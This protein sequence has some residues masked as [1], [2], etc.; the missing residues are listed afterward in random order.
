MQTNVA[1]MLTVMAGSLLCGSADAAGND[2]FGLADELGSV[3]AAALPYEGR[4]S[5]RQVGEPAHDSD[6]STGSLTTNL[7]RF[8]VAA[9]TRYWIRSA[10][11]QSGYFGKLTF[12]IRPLTQPANDRF[13]DALPLA[14][15]RIVINTINFGASTE[16]GEPPPQSR[17]Y[18]Q[19]LRGAPE[20]VFPSEGRGCAVAFSEQYRRSDQRCQQVR[21][22][23]RVNPQF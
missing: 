21:E 15:E 2:S 12:E 9:G 10:T 4:G 20:V 13:A 3:A 5:T 7:Y 18:T 23:F 11:Q 1:L 22:R 16:P 14:G 17:P 19:T 8:T 6:S